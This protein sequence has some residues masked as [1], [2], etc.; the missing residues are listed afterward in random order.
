MG[1]LGSGLPVRQLDFRLSELPD[2]RL[3]RVS[4][5]PHLTSLDPAETP[6]F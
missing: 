1:Y 4:L 3:R 6:T 5:L 2:H